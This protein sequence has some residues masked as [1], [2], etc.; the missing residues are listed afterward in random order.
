MMLI[1]L[2]ALPILIAGLG[3]FTFFRG[4]R[5]GRIGDEPRCRRC[6]YELQGI[7]SP[8]CP[9]C[10][11]PLS[12]TNVVRGRRY[13]RPG[14]AV[15]GVLG[16]LI[17]LGAGGTLA[18]VSFPD[19]D[20]NHYK[21][22]SWLIA[23]LSNTAPS[24]QQNAWTELKRRNAAGSL[25]PSQIAKLVDLTIQQQKA[26]RPWNFFGEMADVALQETLAGHLQ[27]GQKQT[28]LSNIMQFR[29]VVRPKA[30][31]TL[32]YFIGYQARGPDS[33]SITFGNTIDKFAI[34]GKVIEAED[35]GTNRGAFTGQAGG[36]SGGSLDLNDFHVAPGPHTLQVTQVVRLR[37]G[38]YT[39]S[40]ADDTLPKL[41]ELVQPMSAPFTVLPVNT[42]EPIALVHDASLGLSL[43]K[44]IQITGATLN[45]DRLS[46]S[47]DVTQCPCEAVFEVFAVI[48]GGETRLGSV[49]FHTGDN[50]EYFTSGKLPP[51]SKPSRNVIDV[52]LRSS[53]EKARQ[54]VDFTQIWDGELI[55][56]DVPFTRS[57]K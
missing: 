40:A 23:D 16:L 14:L 10:G 22:T 48:N 1:T 6:D 19:I 31:S 17:G 28:F 11:L 43:Q 52:V 26:A 46:C 36:G 18:W 37:T 50:C 12:P 4:L 44:A 45:G 47:V 38:A 5:G 32:P 7:A 13:R 53:P 25:S 34:D 39:G 51:G 29:F 15:A 2:I 27:A 8:Q 9:E 54:T 35:R 20:W 30:R 56:H 3:A 49:S 57:S 21:F 41:I 33:V 55:F 24:I 42:I